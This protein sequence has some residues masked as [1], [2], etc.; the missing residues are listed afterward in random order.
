MITMT[1]SKIG[2]LKVLLEVD[3]LIDYKPTGKVLILASCTKV[4]Q[5]SREWSG[6]TTYVDKKWTNGK[7]KPEYYIFWGNRSD[8]DPAINDLDVM[9]ATH[10]TT[11]RGRAVTQR[12]AIKTFGKAIKAT[13]EI[14]F[15]KIIK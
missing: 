9:G 15:R 3:H 1:H 7:P 14:E 10:I 8:I 2:T 13:N 12:S 11:P 4:P 5:S 6:Y